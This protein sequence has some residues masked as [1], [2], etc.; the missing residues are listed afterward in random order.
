[1]IV[2]PEDIAAYIDD[3]VDDA[4]R[5]RITLAA[6]GDPALAD[7]IAAERALRDR[8]RAHFAP[9][10][11][12]AV[13]ADWIAT[14]RAATTPQVIESA[15]QVIDLAAARARRQVPRW[16]WNAGAG[17]AIAASLLIGVMI[18]GRGHVPF[19]AGQGTLLASG[20]LARVLDH[21]LASAQAD[22]PT[23]ILG[24][25]RR[26]DGG[27]CRVFSGATASGIACHAA[28]GWQMQRVLPGA[29]AQDGTYRQAGS[30]Q[31]DLMAEA[32]DMAA[33]DPLNAAQESAAQKAG[34]R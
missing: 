20:D 7:R 26:Q 15:P 4:A 25:F 8:L 32:Q 30:E 5:T 19:V 34:W 33:G 29:A 21:Q 12:E 1:M 18:G 6:L 22:A 14:I 27:L 9:V 13:P 11:D 24:T 17:V 3:E 28:D 31:A 16:G 2:T 23:R 10:Q